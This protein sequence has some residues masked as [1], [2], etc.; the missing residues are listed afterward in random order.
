MGAFKMPRKKTRA[1]G[2]L[3]P[4][5]SLPSAYGI[6]SFGAAAYNFVDFLA[7]AGQKYWQILPLGPTSYGDSPYQSFS[8]FAGNPYFIDLDMLCGEGLL[9]PDEC[10]EKSWGK[11]EKQVDYGTIFDLREPL[12]RKAFAR[13]K[14]KDALESFRL[15]NAD[16]LENYALYMSIKA[17]MG[18][19]S[20]TEWDDDI[21]L[22]EPAAIK[23]YRRELK[24]DIEYHEFIQ[25]M[26]MKQWEKLKAYANGHGIGIIGDIPIYVAMDSADV[27]A[28]SGYFL[29]DENKMPVDVAGCPPDYFSED[30]QLWGNPL[31]RWDIL[32]ADGYKWWLKR[33]EACLSLYDVLRIDHFRGLESYYAI[34][35]GRPDAKVGEWRK[36]PG[37]DFVGAIHKQFGKSNIIAEDLGLITK[38]VQK[39]L[40]ES[41]FP[42]MKVLQFAFDSKEESVY[43]PHC[44]SENCVVYTGT[45]DNDTIRGWISQTGKR[46]LRF[47][48]QYLNSD[49]KDL[50]WAFIRA[51]L[52]SVSKLVVIPM[53]DYLNLGS[54]ARINIPSTL[55]GD[56]WRW[57]MG[58]NAASH[59]LARKIAKMTKIYYR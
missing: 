53:Q 58:K 52:S 33:L 5:S 26:F 35:F 47:A 31:Y 16:W 38:A 20:W 28:N 23:R 48:M 7:E 10:M 22:R 42:G 46:D 13:F 34:P 3:M 2:I 41:K 12:L 36:G 19:K 55:G 29:L 11:S 57:R 18:L 50:N 40:R 43:L 37:M 49:I 14:D 9:K 4:V 44:L 30:G 45:H 25:Y 54:S 59:A 24:E 21:R 39:L 1:A 27:W 15:E 8:A 6:G 56:N 32:K 17:K 51:A